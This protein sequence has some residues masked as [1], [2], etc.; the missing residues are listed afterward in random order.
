MVNIG[1]NGHSDRDSFLKPEGTLSGELSAE[2]A[3]PLHH[4]HRRFI[5]KQWL[6]QQQRTLRSALSVQFRD[7]MRCG[8]L[9]DMAATD[10]DSL[11]I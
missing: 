9:K 6:K 11:S 8:P 1:L 3:T 5:G 4:S 10:V 7:G 2:H